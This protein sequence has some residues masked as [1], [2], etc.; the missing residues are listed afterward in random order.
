[1]ALSQNRAACY[2][3]FMNHVIIT[4]G[5]GFIGS[6]LCERFLKEG[7]AVTAID[8][9]LTGSPENIETIQSHKNFRFL[10]HDVSDPIPMGAIEFL[11]QHGLYGLLHFA[12]P[13]SPKDFS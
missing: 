12:C 8:N 2:E 1:M 6:H 11:G 10:K 4:G 7:Y 3:N 9:F 13:A 5:A